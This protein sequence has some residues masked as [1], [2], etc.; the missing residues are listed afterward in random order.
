MGSCP[1]LPA[2]SPFSLPQDPMLRA[3]LF[4]VLARLAVP[5]RELFVAA[6]VFAAVGFCM[7]AAGKALEIA[8]FAN[9]WQVLTCYWLYV[10]PLALLTRGLPPA[11]RLV[12]CVAGLVPLELAGYALG[13]SIAF[14]DNIIDRALGARNFTLAMV[15]VCAPI[16]MLCDAVVRRLLSSLR[17]DGP[18][19]TP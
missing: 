19:S 15:V 7:N 1:A 12:F 16:P 14:D 10:L 2:L 5:R 13:T 17:G 18:W 8:C 4:A 11:T 6:G 3:L 9:D